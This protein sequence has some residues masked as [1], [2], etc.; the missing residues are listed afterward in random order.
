MNTICLMGRLTDEPQLKQSQ[1]GKSFINFCIAVERRGKE[2]MIDFID[3]I[4][5]E[6]TAETISKYCHKG[7]QLGIAGSLQTRMYE[8]QTGEKRKAYSVLVN[9]FYFGAK[10][11]SDQRTQPE[12]PINAPHEQI[13]P[14]QSISDDLP[15]QI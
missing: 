3:C 7:D 9:S 1:A 5:F 14:S 12:P 13:N 11:A 8:T 4:A 6:G 10:K 15:F 2:K